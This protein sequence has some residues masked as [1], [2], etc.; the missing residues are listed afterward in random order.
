MFSTNDGLL[1]VGT[2]YFPLYC[3][4]VTVSVKPRCS[5]Y[6]L[7]MFIVGVSAAC[8]R[9][10]IFLLL[11]FNSEMSSLL[12]GLSLS[13]GIDH[14]DLISIKVCTLMTAVNR[15]RKCLVV[16]VQWCNSEV[17]T[18]KK[19]KIYQSVWSI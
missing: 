17:S 8:Y 9:P 1:P 6:P 4:S 3:L 18:N 16:R 2:K 15:N 5:F 11:L 14:T 12:C 7:S 19:K 10:Y 13:A